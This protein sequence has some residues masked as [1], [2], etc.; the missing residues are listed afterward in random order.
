M[1]KPPPYPD[2]ANIV[3]TSDISDDNVKTELLLQ[4]WSESGRFDFPTRYY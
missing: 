4:E 1:S 2:M 3:Q